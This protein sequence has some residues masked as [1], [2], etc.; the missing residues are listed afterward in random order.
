MQVVCLRLGHP[1]ISEAHWRESR[2]KA[3]DVAVFIEDIAR[4]MER[5]LLVDVRYGI[6][7]IVSLKD[8]PWV[9]PA[10]Y[11]ELGYQPRWKVTGDGW[12]DLG[13]VDETAAQ[14]ASP[15]AAQ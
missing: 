13:D 1:F 3:T 7:P 4:A 9:D 11:A 10:L 12:I 14:S 8:D 6:Y 5:A 15:P 2:H